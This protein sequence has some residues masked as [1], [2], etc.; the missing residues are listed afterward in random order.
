MNRR[1]A[2]IAAL[3]WPTTGR[4]ENATRMKYFTVATVA[5]AILLG[6]ASDLHAQ[7]RVFYD[8]FEAGTPTSGRMSTRN[9][10]SSP[11]RPTAERLTAAVTWRSA[12]GMA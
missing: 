4:R 10:P 5:A 1:D 7:G 2:I 11:R 9:A 6:V 3:D 12:I 8:D